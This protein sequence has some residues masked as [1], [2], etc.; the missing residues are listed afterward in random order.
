M[1]AKTQRAAR[2]HPSVLIGMNAADDAGVYKISDDLA[3]VQTVDYFTPVVDDPRDY[4]AIAAANS[5]SDIYAMG[6]EPLT[7]LNIVGFPTDLLSL[8]ILAEILSG[9]QDVLDEAGVALLGGHTV[10]NPEPFFGLAVTGR[11]HPQR[12]L[13]K[14]GARAGDRLIL[15][16]P[17][18]TGLLATGLRNGKL[19][20]ES[21]ALMTRSMRRLNREGLTVALPFDPHAATDITGFGLLGHLHEMAQQ[22]GL[23]AVV[24]ASSVRI[25]PGTREMAEDRQIAGGLRA[26]QLYLKSFLQSEMDKDDWP[27]LAFFDPQTS[28]GLL[29]SVSESSA[30]SLLK[31]LL[32]E[33]IEASQIGRM[34]EGRAGEIVVV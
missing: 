20:E 11:I 14:A 26:N 28:G 7:A 23:R 5:L 33:G 32:Q 25:L 34:E 15:T 30:P 27:M 29:F 9:S 22:S 31:I 1:L 24:E 18:G 4:G 3:L 8:D 6:G 21:L 19:G 2:S 17:I 16:K 10:R 13:T 12:I